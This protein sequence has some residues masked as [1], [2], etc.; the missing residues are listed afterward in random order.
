MS[1][2]RHT[3]PRGEARKQE[4]LDVAL[5][6]FSENGFRGA[7]I[8]DIAQRC[9]ISQGGLLHHFPTKADLLAGVLA[10][11]DE[12]DSHDFHMDQR[13]GGLEALRSIERLVRHNARRVGLVKLFTVVTSEAVTVGNPGRKWVLARYR[14]LQADLADGLQRDIDAG[15]VQ[16]DANPA[17]VACQVFAMMDGL[18]LQWLLDPRRVD[19]PALFSDYLDA[20]IERIAIEPR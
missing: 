11:R 8:A 19:M 1:T 5:K 16:P 7:S 20:L 15:L 6:S 13:P 2:P 18:Q 4:I 3:Q 12:V 9:G 17:A 10:R 14:K